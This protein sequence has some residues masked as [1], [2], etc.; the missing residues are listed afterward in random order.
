MSFALTA[1]RGR[2]RLARLS[3]V[4]AIAGA[5]LGL[6]AVEAGAVS[7]RVEKACTRDYLQFCPQYNEGTPQLRSCMSQAGRRGSLTPRCLNALVD[8]G[9]VPRKYKKR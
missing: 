9:M 6:L 4:A 3:L 2:S 8:S 1:A 5:S 7:R